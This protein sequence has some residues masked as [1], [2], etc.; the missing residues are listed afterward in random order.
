MCILMTSN[1]FQF[2]LTWLITYYM[3]HLS[4]YFSIVCY[5][6]NDCYIR[7]WHSIG[8]FL[9]TLFCVDRYWGFFGLCFR[10]GRLSS[11]RLLCGFNFFCFW[12]S[13]SYF[14]FSFSIFY[15]SFSLFRFSVSFIFFNFI[16]FGF[17]FILF[18]FSF[19][20]FW[21]CF[22]LFWFSDSNFRLSF[23]FFYFGSSYFWFRYSYFRFSFS[24]FCFRFS[25]FRFSYSFLRFRVS[26]F[27]FIRVFLLEIRRF[28]LF[29]GFNLFI[30]IYWFYWFWYFIGSL[31][32]ARFIIIRCSFAGV[33]V[34]VCLLAKKC[35]CSD[36]L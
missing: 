20:N 5:S 9:A 16:N 14:G 34:F 3:T 27:R 18:R 29:L 30:T 4:S 33:F 15:V 11:F 31:L 23:S 28:T 25:N 8:F 21:L 32:C 7:L 26:K 10:F 6:I 35:M 1:T 36:A 12:F 17:C 24:F 2:P 13:F 22:S 19:S